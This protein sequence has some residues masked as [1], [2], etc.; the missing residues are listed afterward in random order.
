YRAGLG[1]LESLFVANKEDIAATTGVSLRICE[2]ICDKVA[3]HLKEIETLPHDAARSGWRF[4]LAGMA[5]RLRDE[6]E[7]ERAPHGS[8]G[9]LTF[10]EQRRR[11]QRQLYFLEITVILAEMGELN[12]LSRMQ[13]VSFKRRIQ[14]LDDYL[15]RPEATVWS[16]TR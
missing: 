16:V 12:L 1:S 10:E 5:N 7:V 6:I 15:A 3:R 2:L 13:K 4:R 11:H 14:I 8:Q 9:C